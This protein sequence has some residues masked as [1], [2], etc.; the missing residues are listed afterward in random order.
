MAGHR[1]PDAAGNN[2]AFYAATKHALRAITEGLRQEV[3]N[4]GIA[5]PLSNSALLTEDRQAL[6]ISPLLDWS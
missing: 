6:Y 4:T 3:R 2:G 5:P 1:I